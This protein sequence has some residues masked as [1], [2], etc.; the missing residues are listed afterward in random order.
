MTKKD[1]AVP[2]LC[3]DKSCPFWRAGRRGR[4]WGECAAGGGIVPG[5][6]SA[7]CPRKS[8]EFRGLLVTAGSEPDAE[9]ER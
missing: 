8:E 3:A 4:T 7:D 1:M 6:L 2:A 5:R 9:A